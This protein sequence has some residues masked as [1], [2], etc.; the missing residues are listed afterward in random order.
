MSSQLYHEIVAQRGQLENL[1][2]KIPGFKGYHEK[3]AR[4]Q[5][6][7]LLREY[8]VSEFDKILR[9]FERFE[10][11][12]LDNGGLQYMGRTREV[13]SKIDAYRDRVNTAAP[14]YSGMW[15]AIKIDEDALD[16]IYAFDEAQLRYQMQFDTLLI[17]LDDAVKAD[18]DFE[19]IL[20]ELYDAAVE[21]NEAFRL[22]DDEILRLADTM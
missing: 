6:D 9:R 17:R 13:K 3:E 22:R 7:R 8:L 12:L 10:K 15:S 19:P 5:A 20:D 16:R 21:A 11:R 2:A 18:E 4:R 14:K 1:V